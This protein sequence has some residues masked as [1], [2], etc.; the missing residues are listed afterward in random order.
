MNTKLM[1]TDSPGALEFDP[2]KNSTKLIFQDMSKIS[3]E[4]K[5]QKS[6]SFPLVLNFLRLYFK[7]DDFLAENYYFISFQIKLHC[8]ICL[9]HDLFRIQI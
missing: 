9:S 4:T 8:I 3:V 7:M 5:Y 6:P 1:S 2:E